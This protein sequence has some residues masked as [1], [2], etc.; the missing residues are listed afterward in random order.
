MRI[1]ASCTR[2]LRPLRW[3]AAVVLAGAFSLNSVSAQDMDP[4]ARVI[5]DP[6]FVKWAL[7][8]G[9]LLLALFMLGWSYRRDLLRVINRQ[10]Q[11][12]KVLLEYIRE[13]TRVMTQTVDAVSGCPFHTGP[14]PGSLPSTPSPYPP[15]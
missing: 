1:T 2:A 3:P 10:E 7:Q 11:R 14:R 13:S 15:G 12:E 6:T 4:A 9:G 5:S 8:Q